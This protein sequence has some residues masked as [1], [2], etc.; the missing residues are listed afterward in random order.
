MKKVCQIASGNNIKFLAPS[1]TGRTR[2]A[3]SSSEVLQCCICLCDDPALALETNCGHVYCAGDFFEFLRRVAPGAPP[4]CPYCRQ[5]VTLLL[6]FF[7]EAE[8]AAPAETEAAEARN[9]ILDKVGDFNRRFSGESEGEGRRRRTSQPMSASLWPPSLSVA[10]LVV[11]S[12]G[13][14]DV[15][16][17]SKVFV[18]L[19]C[20]LCSVSTLGQLL[21]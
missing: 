9:G 16:G 19:I 15:W 2:P 11:V 10:T 6:P 20:H 7:T 5:R 18:A 1:N 13:D 4:G 12:D 21:R 17:R 14:V 8:R 3:S